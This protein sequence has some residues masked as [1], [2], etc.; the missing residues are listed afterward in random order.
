M[1][2]T[3]G[4]GGSGVSRCAP[5]GILAIL[6]GCEYLSVPPVHTHTMHAIECIRATKKTN[7]ARGAVCFTSEACTS[8]IR[9]LEGIGDKIVGWRNSMLPCW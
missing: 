6:F 2:E 3:G 5:A 7:P 4:G 1:G 8:C 9:V